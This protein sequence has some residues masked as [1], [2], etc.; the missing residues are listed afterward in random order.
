MSAGT[1]GVVPVC[2]VWLLPNGI[3]SADL[4]AETSGSGNTFEG[5][6]QPHFPQLLLRNRGV[7]R[8]IINLLRQTLPRE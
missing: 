5:Y 1:G 3:L 6:Y 7:V 2:T 8:G 4:L